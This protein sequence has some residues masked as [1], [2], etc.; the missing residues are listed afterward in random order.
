[1]PVLEAFASNTP[2]VASNTT[3]IPEVAKDAAILIDPL[4]PSNIASALSRVV[5]NKELAEILV[6]K[7]L[8]RANEMTWQ[9]C[10]EDTFTEYKKV[11]EE[12]V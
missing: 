10:A 9:R 2:V 11:V 5:E 7:G 6:K 8:A 1:M 4:D 3:S 12:Y